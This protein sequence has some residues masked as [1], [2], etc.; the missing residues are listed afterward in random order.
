[1]DKIEF[2]FGLL[3]SVYGRA[4]VAAQWPTERDEQVVKAL[5]ADKIADMTIGDIRA[6]IDNA[7]TQRMNEVRGW[8]WPDVDLILQGSKRY[9][10]AAHK[11]FLPE[12][13]RVLPDA[14]ER[15]AIIKKL[16]EEV[17]L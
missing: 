5:I 14:S 4:K 9:G 17:G 16:R 15:A 6:S 1:M 2:F 12:P 10:T 3:N 8:D 13:Q 7:R 11:P